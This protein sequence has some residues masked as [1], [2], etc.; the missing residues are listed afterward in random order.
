MAKLATILALYAAAVGTFLLLDRRDAGGP[1]SVAPEAAPGSADVRQVLAEVRSL[2]REELKGTLK[3]VNW[4]FAE[5]DKLRQSMAEG[6]EAMQQA[7]EDAA[8]A[9]YGMLETMKEDVER[10]GKATA[11]VE[12]MVA[13]LEALEKRLKAVEDRPAQV[14]RETIL[15]SDGTATPTKGSEP[16]RRTLPTGPKKDPAVVEKEIAEAKKGLASDDLDVL[17]P[18]IEKIREYRVLEVVPRLVE[19][20]ANHKDEFGRMAAASALGDMRAADGVLPLAEALVDKSALVADQANKAI[21]Q[22]TDH[23]TGLVSG[24]GIRRR[25]AARNKLKEWWRDHEAEIRTAL[26]QPKPGG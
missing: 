16:E 20:L 4:R 7:S 11:N 12:T 17:F 8:Q 13:R 15:K 22:I 1:G 21:R 2:W 3:D 18:A 5:M 19:I 24:A 14:I 9:N 25:R 26:G 23:D 10:F 6:L